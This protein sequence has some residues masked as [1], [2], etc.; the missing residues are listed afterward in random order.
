MHKFGISVAILC[1]L[2]AA[3]NARTEPDVI[4]VKASNVQEGSK[5]ISPTGQTASAQLVGYNHTDHSISA[6]YV[7]GAWGG[8]LSSGEGGGGFVCCIDMPTAWHEGYS[9]LVEWED[10]GGTAQKRHVPVPK[11]DAKKMAA[12][13]VHFLRD[14]QIKVF[15]SPVFLGHPDYPLQG[16]QAK[17]PPGPLERRAASDI[18]K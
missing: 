16:E 1:A 13:G 18:S 4:A 6:F 8:Q 2:L 12:V 9:V 5:D 15:A 3:C 11:Y 14:G 10:Q 17:M 7:N